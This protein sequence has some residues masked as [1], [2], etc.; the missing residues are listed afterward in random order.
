V[1]AGRPRCA[2]GS[3]VQRRH[4][5]PH[6]A[7]GPG[8]RLDAAQVVPGACALLG[9]AVSARAAAHQPD[10]RAG[11]AALVRQ[12]RAQR[13][14]LRRAPAAPASNTSEEYARDTSRP[15]D[16]LSRRSRC[17][18]CRTGTH[19]SAP[20]D[21]PERSKFYCYINF[22]EHA[23]TPCHSHA[24]RCRLHD[25]M[26]VMAGY[27]H[28]QATPSPFHRKPTLHKWRHKPT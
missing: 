27:E 25:D 24:Y 11:L 20:C 1:F 18:T 3:R 5:V 16:E 9:A 6:N 8:P 14:A 12:E 10:R 23:I 7:R 19:N 4:P 13:L 28:V 17:R 15:V 21:S 2:S 26:S 22:S